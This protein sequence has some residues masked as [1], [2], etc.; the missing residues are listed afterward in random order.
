MTPFSRAP[1]YRVALVARPLRTAFNKAR[2]TIG[3]L[4]VALCVRVLLWTVRFQV[5]NWAAG[6]QITRE[7]D[8]VIFA[9]WHNSVIIPLGHE[10]RWHCVAL[11]SPG[12]DGTFAARIIRHFGVHSA[13]GSTSKQG[14]EGMLALLRERPASWS[15]VIT[16]DGPRGPR[17]Q[18]QPGLA[19]LGSRSGLPIVPIGMALSRAWH[20]RSW[21][22]FRIPKPFSRAVMVFGDPLRLAPD[23]D[24]E[25]LETARVSLENTIRDVTRRAHEQVGLTWPD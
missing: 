9:F 3:T 25:E 21:D 4:V 11:V 14:A 8:G 1:R 22:R 13:R 10:S 23:M 24:R 2:N 6:R 16:P 7:G 15:L 18:V 5:I 20:L 19:Y 12:G 17:Y